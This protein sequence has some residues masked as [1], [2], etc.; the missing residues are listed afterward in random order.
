MF[1][2][3]LK[4]IDAKEQNTEMLPVKSIASCNCLEA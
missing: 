4:K 2:L 1:V 3:S